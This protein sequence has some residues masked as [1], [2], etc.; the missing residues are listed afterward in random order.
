V[1][2]SPFLTAGRSASK[3]EVKISNKIIELF[4]EGLYSSPNKAIEE[5]VSNSFDAGANHVH[6]ILSGDLGDRDAT[7]VVIDDGG[8]MDAGGFEQHWVIGT[9]NKRDADYVAPKGRRQIGK[10]GIGKLATYVLANRLTHISKRD[11]HYYAVTMDYEKVPTGEGKGIFAKSPLE[12]PLRELSESEAQ[13]ALAPWTSGTKT[14]YTTLKLFGRGAAKSWTVAILSSLKGMAGEIRRGRL[15]WILASAMPLRDDFQ[16]FLNGDLV[17]PAKS[18]GKKIG[19]WILGKSLLEVPKPAPDDGEPVVDS[20]EDVKSARY[21]GLVFPQLGRVS[22]YVEAYVDPLDKG[23]SN[24]IERSHG[25]FV[26][27]HDRLINVDDAGFGIDRN[28]LRHGTFSRFRMVLFA[29]ALDEE[30]RSSRETLRA[31]PLINDARNLAIGAFNFA[32]TKIE[33]YLRRDTTGSQVASRVES[34]PA[35]L[36]RRPLAGLV[37][38][39]FS[40]AY[41]PRYV[42]IPHDFSILQQDELVESLRVEK[43]GGAPLV[44]S[45]IL[46]SELSQD[47]PVAVFEVRTGTL[48]INTLHPFVAYFLDEFEDK[49]RSLPLE[50]IAMSEVLLEANLHQLAIPESQIRDTLERRD[51]LLR[52]L[53]RSSG[54][55][56]ARMISQALLDAASDQ[57]LLE[58]ELVAS[59]DS[60]GY[61]AV[62]IGGNKRA[63]GRAAAYLSVRNGK[64]QGYTV[65]LEAKSKVKPGTK[66]TAKTVGVSTI[67]RHR[68]DAKCE[69]AIVVG[70]DFPTAQGETTA[71]ADEIKHD[72]DTNLGKTITLIRIADLA[73]LVRLVPLRR[74]GLDRLRD[75]FVSCSLPE[76]AKEWIDKIEAESSPQP[77]YRQILDIIQEEQQK[78][79]DEL[80]E[81]GIV[82][83]KLRDSYGINLKQDEVIDTCKALSR[84]VPQ[85]VTVYDNSVEIRMKPTKILAAVQAV[86]GEFSESER[87]KAK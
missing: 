53:A 56:N 57:D 66:V 17:V 5:L 72:R 50:L 1:A 80:V 29:D 31:G 65:C 40:G 35:A 15:E 20:A 86:I 10:F 19:T 51:Q 27:V 34:S 46:V 33:D 59:F 37:A 77:P 18:R 13:N 54:Q 36:T 49:K 41:A 9:S 28:K 8:G 73:R 4:S 30:L 25:F 39:A 60:M 2:P 43:E 55:R 87:G 26:Y 74:L 21:N 75:L 84:F 12:L 58:E 44:Q 79:A 6:V 62:R 7:I 3:I 38:A 16:L 85:W 42:T 64:R 69:H 11:G 76:Q 67:A 70:P 78:S 45:S 71:L 83:S 23:K 52:E 14:G 63:D 81:I 24:E 47:Q 48:K 61:E 82:R 68:R 22:G 32:R